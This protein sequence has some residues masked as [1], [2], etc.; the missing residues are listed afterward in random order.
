MSIKSKLEG[1]IKDALRAGDKLRLS[2]LRML[3]ARVVDAEVAARS[4][5]GKTA[6]LDDDEEL[7]VIATYA[8]QRRDSIDSYVAGGREDL[9][10][11]ERQELDIV[12]S[13]LPQQLSEG[14][15]RGIVEQA[16]AE[17]GASSAADL[18]KVM[19]ILMPRVKGT[20]DGKLVS[21]IVR[22]TLAS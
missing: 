22:E 4:K 15:L 12:N 16:I 7:A 2:C 8:K 13:Y 21:R 14:E 18:G 11:K 1:E 3:K 17:A 5:R 20:A 19:K 10:G 6:E 9:A